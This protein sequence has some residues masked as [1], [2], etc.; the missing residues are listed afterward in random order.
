MTNEEKTMGMTLGSWRIVIERRTPRAAEI[1]S[2]YD[3][4]NWYW[5]SLPHRMVYGRAYFRLFRELSESGELKLK[6]T[7]SR[8]L[9]FGIGAGLFSE[10]LLRARDHE[11]EVFGLDLSEKMLI[12]AQRN[13]ARYAVRTF[14]R[15]GDFRRLPHT[16]GEM[17]L[18]I[19]ALA[20][21]H[22]PR[23]DAVIGELARVLRR[24]GT[25][26]LVATRASA[27]DFPWR[28]LYRYR[29]F[30]DGKIEQMMTAAGLCAVRR[31]P[32]KGL[33]RYFAAA[34]VGKKR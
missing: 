15:Q 11:F 5:S 3:R 17:D 31:V 27:P 10:A 22:C 16:D 23:P 12:R 20:L 30:E 1:E 2:L 29:H 14:L 26:V 13:L 7:P 8:V 18:S 6:S 4:T 28:L 24:D 19:S 32:L 33:A 34:Y 9:D 25:L 21:E